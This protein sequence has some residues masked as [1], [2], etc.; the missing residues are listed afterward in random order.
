MYR[1]THILVALSLLLLSAQ[2]MA[3]ESKKFE[4]DRF[5]IGLWVD[6]PVDSKAEARYKELAEANFNVVIGGFGG[7]DVAQ[8]IALCEALDLKL[9]ASARG[10]EAIATGESGHLGLCDSRRAQCRRFS[11]PP[12]GLRCDSCGPAWKIALYQFVPQLCPGFSVG[13][14]D[15]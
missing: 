13:D 11:G 8:Q 7:A 6:P 14:R 1:S 12:C 15:L 3:E 9:I 4:Q 10:K 5:A 2:S